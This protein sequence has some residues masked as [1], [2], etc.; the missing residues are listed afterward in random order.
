M[1]IAE[2]YRVVAEAKTWLNTPY[3]PHARVKGV[4]V[5]CAM[6]PAEVYHACG[7]IP[8]VDVD[9][10]PITWHLHRS[11]ERYENTVLKYA[12]RTD[13][14]EVGNFILYKIGR[15]FSHGGII[16]NWPLIIHSWTGIGVLIADGTKGRLE[17]RQFRVYT[18]WEETDDGQ[19]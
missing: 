12:T 6:L 3:H 8:K 18:L 7:V 2:R 13:K 15:C 19:D 1:S 14:L 10:Y 4:G 17:G 11:E 16:V 9:L 5:D